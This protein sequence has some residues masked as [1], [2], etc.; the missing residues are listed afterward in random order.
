VINKTKKKSPKEIPHENFMGG[1][2]YFISDPIK[3]LRIVASTCFF[4]EPSYYKRDSTPSYMPEY[5]KLSKMLGA[6]LPDDFFEEKS[7]LSDVPNAKAGNLIEK[8]IDK[9]LDFDAEATLKEAV[10]LRKEE[11][12]R[13][14]PQV[15]LVRAAHHPNVRGTSLIRRYAPE[16]IQRADEPSTGLAYHFSVYGQ[17]AAIPNALKKAW[18]KALESFSRHELAKYKQ[19]DREVKMVD[20]VNLVHP[21]GDI[22]GELVKGQLK[23][24]GSTW[25]SMI[26]KSGSTTEN[27]SEAIQVMGHMALLRNLR[28]F[29]EKKV[30]P[31][32][33]LAKLI[34]TSKNGKQLPFRYYSAHRALLEVSSNPRIHN[35][36]EK[37][38]TSALGNL[39]HFKGRLM[40][41][42][43]NSGS[44]H[45]TTTS[46][47]GS[48]KVADIGNLTS[49][50][51][52]KCAD[53]GYVGVFGDRL[54]IIPVKETSSV[55]DDVKKVE[56]K[57]QRIGSATEN[58]I[59]IFWRDAIKNK[60]H[61]DN[62]FVFSD[63]QAGHGGLYG[64]NPSEYSEYIWGRGRDI[65]VAALIRK[66]R[67]TVNPNV[68]VFLVQTAG[69]NDTIV[70][71]FYKRTYILGGWGEGL[72]KFA[73]EMEKMY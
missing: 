15:M 12:I 59:W 27:W 28:N 48:M 62:V 7:S 54:E 40:A 38:L 41:L 55:F 37:C 23:S 66:Y 8:A 56:E 30:D 36:I 39:P 32:L 68:N 4:G 43:D 42:S 61:W 72:L 67:A 6:I 16:I 2:S 70:P 69:Y 11:H 57:G 29:V 26:S 19:G 25:E 45:G 34:E 33:Y 52:A 22:F 64:E 49:V 63:M 73:A 20:V 5:K 13:A 51:A 3:N 14:T 35:A 1:E 31:T 46:S 21:K 17:K 65:D 47:M 24:E 53:E 9:A 44:A 60:E 10:R 50:I 71:E 18:A 58:G